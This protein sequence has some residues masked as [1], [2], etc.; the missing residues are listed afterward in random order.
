MDVKLKTATMKKARERGLS[1]SA[2]LNLA[3]R[4]FVA[5][6]I[7]VDVL[8]DDLLKAREDVHFGRVISQDKLFRRLGI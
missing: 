2:F 4:A 3:A 6:R 7:D 1:L 5:G 8:G